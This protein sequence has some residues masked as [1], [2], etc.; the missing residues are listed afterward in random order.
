[1]L[2]RQL[3]TCLE[4]SQGDAQRV[5]IAA[6]V[7]S[8]NRLECF[9]LLAREPEDLICTDG[10]KNMD[11]IRLLLATPLRIVLAEFFPPTSLSQGTVS[12]CIRRTVVRS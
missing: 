6:R 12:Y 7:P 3:T 1:M 4:T 8:L 2:Q 5:R 11:Y 10:E 9:S